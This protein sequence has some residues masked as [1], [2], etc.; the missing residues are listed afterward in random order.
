MRRLSVELQ[1]ESVSQRRVPAPKA[2]KLA[3]RKRSYV[4]F[5]ASLHAI[6]SDIAETMYTTRADVWDI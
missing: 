3:V 5:D 6:R 4:V 1:S 2:R